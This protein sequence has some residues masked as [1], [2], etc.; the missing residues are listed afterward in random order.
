MT[1]IVVL[2]SV[3]HR[4]MRVQ[5]E[6]AAKFGDNQR[7]VQ[8]VVGEFPLLVTHYPILFSKDTE[9]GAFLCGAM[10]GID[11][12]ENLFL[13]E[14]KGH[15]AYRPLNLQRVPFFVAGDDLAID[16]DHPRVAV[17]AGQSLFNDQGVPTPYLDSIK[18]AFQQ[19][20]PGVEMTKRF[21]E[22]LLKLNLL[23]PVDIVLGFDDGTKRNLADL[24]T[25]N[26]DV[27]RKL[28]DAAV[29]ELF[30]RGYLQ[31]IYLLIASLKQIP[32]LA[33]KKNDRFLTG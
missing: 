1:N 7:F 4:D 11:E 25:V 30:R 28:P 20:K 32:V 23:E 18:A 31:L 22:T 2:N 24:Y 17:H 10:L 16:L 12:G 3:T 8:V 5:A 15:E 33:Q 26:Q 21:I 29:I 6:A 14:G 9:T 13:K 27:L 19:L